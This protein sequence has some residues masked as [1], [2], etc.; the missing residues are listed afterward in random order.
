MKLTA[1]VERD[2]ITGQWRVLCDLH[3]EL[4]RYG[5]YWHAAQ[6]AIAHAESCE[7]FAGNDEDPQAAG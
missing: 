4:A 7:L 2:L 5:K 1:H 6:D 3:G